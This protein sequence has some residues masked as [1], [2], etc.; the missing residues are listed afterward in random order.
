VLIST[1]QLKFNIAFQMKNTFFLLICFFGLI[2]SS[3][4]QAPDS[5]NAVVSDAKKV[6]TIDNAK[7]Y[8]ISPNSTKIAWIGTKVSGR[9]NGLIDISGGNLDVA[10]GK[11]VAGMFTI[12]MTT[13]IS[14]DAGKKLGDHLKSADFFN[15][16]EFPTAEFE[17]TSVE[18][19][20]FNETQ[21]PYE[22][23]E[24]NQYKVSNPTHRVSGNLTM[25]GV[26]KNIDFPARIEFLSQ[27]LM[28]VAQFN[29]NRKDWGIDFAG[30]SDDL[31]RDDVHIGLSLKAK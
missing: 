12:D 9:H 16:A 29:I 21:S 28:A 20:S 5:D 2:L 4:K 19:R 8:Q 7:S 13:L 3:C 26:T 18:A 11:L 25:H 31:I 6:S 22:Y 1:L 30:K 15:V 23:E 10:N 24:H 17:I 14:V 27:G